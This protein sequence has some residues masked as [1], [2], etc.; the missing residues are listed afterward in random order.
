MHFKPVKVS[1]NGFELLFKILLAHCALPRQPTHTA[2]AAAALLCC[3]HEE[4]GRKTKGCC[5]VFIQ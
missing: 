4:K 1:F 5:F 2:T 3:Y